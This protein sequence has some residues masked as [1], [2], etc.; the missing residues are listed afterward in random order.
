MQALSGVVR[1]A[2]RRGRVLLVED[3]PRV[4]AQARRLLERS[5]FA[6]TDA[7]DGAEGLFQFR[8]RDGAIDVV[9]SDVMM[10]MLGGVEM[11]AHLRAI[12][13]GVPVV[14]VSGYTADDRDLPLDAR[15]LFIPKPYS[16]DDL[17]AAIDSLV[18]S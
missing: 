4:R 10:P 14:F 1:A 3:E 5:G 8:A 13:P 6:V 2:G 7:P 18:T 17:C 16:I 9:V 11:V 12:A 15:T